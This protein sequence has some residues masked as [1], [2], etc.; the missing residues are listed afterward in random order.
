M[1]ILGNQ[2]KVT[3]DRASLQELRE[4][5]KEAC[6]RVI[7]RELVL[8][9]E[10]KLFKFCEVVLTLATIYAREGQRTQA[11]W[12][13]NILI[14]HGSPYGWYGIA[15]LDKQANCIKEAQYCLMQAALAEAR[16]KA[17]FEQAKATELENCLFKVNKES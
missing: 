6:N 3:Q 4:L 10:L 12:M 11:C 13:Y 15:E 8:P 16:L 17:R 9:Q 5:L 1:R 7:D 2:V 14:D